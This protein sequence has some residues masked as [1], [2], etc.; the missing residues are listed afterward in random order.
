MSAGSRQQAVSTAKCAKSRAKS[1]QRQQAGSA[2]KRANSKATSTAREGVHS[3]RRMALRGCPVNQ[4]PSV[5]ETTSIKGGHR[6]GP[7]QMKKTLNGRRASIKSAICCLRKV[8]TGT[9]RHCSGWL[10]LRA[11]ALSSD[12]QLGLSGSIA[13]SSSE[14]EMFA[15]S[16]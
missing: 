3:I 8:T 5:V 14:Q 10:T 2:A 7:S 16:I 4:V 12:R 15:T 6:K 11:G 1:A 9:D 13:S